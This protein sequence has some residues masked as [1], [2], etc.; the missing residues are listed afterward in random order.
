MNKRNDINKLQDRLYKMDKNLLIAELPN[1]RTWQNKKYYVFDKSLHGSQD[2][3]YGTLQ[4]IEGFI[5]GLE[6]NKIQY[7]YSKILKEKNLL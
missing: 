7:D 2:I 6:Y 3:V 4:V 1:S 5:T